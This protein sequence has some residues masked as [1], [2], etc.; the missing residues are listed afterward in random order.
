MKLGEPKQFHD[1][2]HQNSGVDGKWYVCTLTEK[3]YHI[4]WEYDDDD[5]TNKYLHSDGVLR[6][7]TVNEDTS[8][9]TGYFATEADA[10]N[11]RLAYLENEK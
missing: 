4:H 3:E 1:T 2:I 10:L 5:S 9:Y 7:S 8:K 6:P 11:A